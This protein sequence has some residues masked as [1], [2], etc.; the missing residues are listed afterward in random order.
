MLAAD[1][2]LNRFG[3]RLVREMCVH[4]GCFRRRVTELLF[5]LVDIILQIIVG[6][7]GMPQLMNRQV[8]LAETFGVLD[9]HRLNRAFRHPFSFFLSIGDGYEQGLLPLGCTIS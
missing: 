3:H 4:F 7:E 2:A 6:G 1:P 5:G 9:N 8:R